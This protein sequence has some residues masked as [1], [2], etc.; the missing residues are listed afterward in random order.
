MK[1]LLVFLLLLAVV[2][3]GPVGLSSADAA[4]I[5]APLPANAFITHNGADWAWAFPLP[6]HS[7]GFD[8]SF[9]GPLGWRIPTA[10][11]LALAPLATDFLF[12]GGNVPLGG[13]DAVSGASFAFGNAALNNDGAVAV[14]Y[15]STTHLHADWGQGLGEPFGPWWGMA[16]ASGSAEQLV[17]R[18]AVTVPE[19]SS[20]ALLGLGALGLVFAHRRRRNRTPIA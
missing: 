20:I 2:A 8:L 12:A 9:Q 16:G 6:G 18:G 4:I 3:V 7:V 17:I 10:A 14:P 11:E 5:N 19:P 1:Q 13:V 15:F